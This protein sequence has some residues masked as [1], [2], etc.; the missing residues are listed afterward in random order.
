M[1]GPTGRSGRRAPISSA[2]ENSSSSKSTV[3]GGISASVARPDLEQLAHLAARVDHLEHEL[4]HA[5]AEERGLRARRERLASSFFPDPGGPI[6]SSP[7][8]RERA[9]VLVDV[10]FVMRAGVGQHL[11]LRLLEP[12]DLLA[13][14]RRRRHELG[15]SARAAASSRTLR[16]QRFCARSIWIWASSIQ[17][18]GREPPPGRPIRRRSPRPDARA[19]AAILRALRASASPSSRGLGHGPFKAATRVRIPL[20]TPPLC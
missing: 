3:S 7:R 9:P 10:G 20:G 2:C 19:A 18:E 17:V 14:D 12:A 1:I 5:D 13:V 6:S 11:V 8:R 15:T 4:R 16:S